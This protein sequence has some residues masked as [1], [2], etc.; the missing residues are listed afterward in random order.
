MGQPVVRWQIV[1]ANP[2]ATVGFY[3]NLFGWTAKRDN[4]LGYLDVSP[5]SDGIGGG[6]WPAPPEAAPFVQLFVE[7]P[8]VEKYI[9]LA[10]QLGA[11]V[12]VPMSSLPDGDTMAVLLDPAGLSFGIV[13]S[14][15]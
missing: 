8:D 6:V 15:E 14:R 9:A 3:R 1:S 13:H 11:K 7:V 5:G 12:L 2:D 10:T 4:A